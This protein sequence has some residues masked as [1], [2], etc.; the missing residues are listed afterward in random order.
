VPNGGVSLHRITIFFSANEYLQLKKKKAITK[1][2]K[3]REVSTLDNNIDR[4]QVL[5]ST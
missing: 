1:K 4:P 5:P 2:Y 3:E